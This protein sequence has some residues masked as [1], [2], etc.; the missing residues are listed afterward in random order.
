MLS[1]TRVCLF[2]LLVATGLA[3]SMSPPAQASP[4]FGP[5]PSNWSIHGFLQWIEQRWVGCWS[6]ETGESGAPASLTN[7][8][9][10]TIG[11]TGSG[12]G[13]TGGGGPTGPGLIPDGFQ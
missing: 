13:G 5:E 12:I 2:L 10:A 6:G 3:L 7:K 9:G 4:A 11:A 8:D 1:R